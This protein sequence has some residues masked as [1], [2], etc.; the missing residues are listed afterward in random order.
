MRYRA[1]AEIEDLAVGEC[2]M[3]RGA[4]P[5]GS[6]WHMWFRALRETDGQPFDFCVPMKPNGAYSESGPGGK[7]WGLTNLGAGRWQ[8]SPS[9][10]VLNTG[11]THAGEH[12]TLPSLWHQTP[13]I[14][15]VPDDVKWNGGAP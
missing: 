8:V 9:I 7:T 15:D 14:T 6:Y 5:D 13:V 3:H 4:G 1:D 11:D 2:T 10:N 12:P